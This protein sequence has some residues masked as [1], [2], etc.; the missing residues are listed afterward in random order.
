MLTFVRSPQALIGRW[1]V[2]NSF[3][4]VYVRDVRDGALVVGD[5]ACP[6]RIPM[7]LIRSVRLVSPDGLP[8]PEIHIRGAE[9]EAA[10][11]D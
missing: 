11:A 6:A 1:L 4:L 7:A 8:G 9:G 10:L 2:L 3:G 5:D